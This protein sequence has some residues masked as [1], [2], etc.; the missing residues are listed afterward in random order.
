L[1]KAVIEYRGLEKQAAPAKVQI[2]TA[3]V[4]P[5][6]SAI[7]EPSVECTSERHFADEMKLSSRF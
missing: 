5:N 2:C 7:G 3:S 1:F 6:L 4:M